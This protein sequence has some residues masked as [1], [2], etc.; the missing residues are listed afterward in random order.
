MERLKI[1]EIIVVEGIHDKQAVLRVADADIWVL[2]GDRISHR[3]M[4]EL[5]RA[6]SKRGLIIMTDP[7]GPGERIRRRLEAV[8]PG[9][10]HAFVAKSK[11][12]GDGAVGIEHASDDAIRAALKQVKR[13]RPIS[14]AAPSTAFAGQFTTADLVDA[15]LVGS[16]DAANRRQLV[17]EILGIGYGNAKAFLYKLNALGV[18]RAEWEHA[19]ATAGLQRSSV[20]ESPSIWKSK[21]A[22]V[23]EGPRHE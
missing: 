12:L 20:G 23:K 4:A 22:S 2:G 7:D 16:T 13:S 14:N 10:Q 9:S 1:E 11:A 5:T 8:L 3:L 19:L 15:G 18:E 17:G 6:A 21:S